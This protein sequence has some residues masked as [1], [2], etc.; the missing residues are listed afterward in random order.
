LFVQGLGPTSSTIY[1]KNFTDSWGN[2]QKRGKR[3]KE[4]VGSLGETD[5]KFTNIENL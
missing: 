5:I 3:Q 1:E 2:K 4:R